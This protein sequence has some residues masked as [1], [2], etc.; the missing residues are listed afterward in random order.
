MR[1]LLDL[2]IVSL[3]LHSDGVLRSPAA[4]VQEAGRTHATWLDGSQLLVADAA[5]AFTSGGS[6][7]SDSALQWRDVLASADSPQDMRSGALQGASLL[8]AH[9]QLLIDQ[10]QL[11]A[12]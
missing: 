10:A 12:H 2:G 9:Q 5:F 7:H 8:D 3:Q 6:G 11:M 4:G 1:H